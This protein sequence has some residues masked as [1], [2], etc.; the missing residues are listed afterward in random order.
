MSIIKIMEELSTPVKI[1]IIRGQTN[2]TELECV[3]LLEEHKGD[4]ICIIKQYMG[5]STIKKEPPIKSVNQEI[6]KQFRRKLD[7]QEFNDKQAS[8]LSE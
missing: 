5:I 2:Y 3:R 1:A 8:A 4:Y 6:Y 7:I